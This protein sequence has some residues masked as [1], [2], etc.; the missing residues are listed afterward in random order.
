M[1]II[2]HHSPHRTELYGG[3]SAVTADGTVLILTPTRRPAEAL[4]VLN[5]RFV[6]EIL[7]D[8]EPGN[9]W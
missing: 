9:W 3:I 6:A 8:N 5:Q 4:I 1:R 7:L 2:R